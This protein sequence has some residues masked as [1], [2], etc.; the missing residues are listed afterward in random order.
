MFDAAGGFSRVRAEQDID[1]GDGL[2]IVFAFA[3][4]VTYPGRKVR[5]GDQFL[6]EPGEIRDMPQMHYTRGA[7]TAW[8]GVRG[9][10]CFLKIHLMDSTIPG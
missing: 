5:D 3:T 4:H 6:S 7:L 2:F 10:Q 9:R 8:G 1:P